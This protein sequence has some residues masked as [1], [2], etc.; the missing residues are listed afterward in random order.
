MLRRKTDDQ[1][2]LQ[3]RKEKQKEKSLTVKERRLIKGVMQGKTLIQAGVE[4]GY[5][6]STMEKMPGKIIG[7]NRIL[8]AFTELLEEA[9]LSDEKLSECLREGLEATKII[10]ALISAPDGEH[11]KGD[12]SMKKDF[13]EVPDYSTRHKFLETILKLK[14]MFP[15]T[16]DPPASGG[17]QL[18]IHGGEGENTGCKE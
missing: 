4:A 14:S 7:K 18:I 15:K 9:G 2:I 3:M 16:V 8:K 10:S 17:F 12:N 1:T 11:M 5:A 6:R 13:I